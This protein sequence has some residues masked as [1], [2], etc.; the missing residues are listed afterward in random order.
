MVTWVDYWNLIQDLAV[1]IGII[2]CTYMLVNIARSLR[3]IVR[4]L[5]HQEESN[6]SGDTAKVR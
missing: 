4:M 5:Q 2:T 3:Q 1:F 6:R